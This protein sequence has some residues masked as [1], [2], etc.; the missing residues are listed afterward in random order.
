MGSFL[1][2]SDH[3]LGMKDIDSCSNL[4]NQAVMGG[5]GRDFKNRLWLTDLALLKK[6]VNAILL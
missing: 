6:K 4:G 5:V 2:N 1:S 3:I